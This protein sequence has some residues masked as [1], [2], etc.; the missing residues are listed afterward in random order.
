[1]SLR[2]R[3]RDAVALADAERVEAGGGAL[4]AGV[5][6]GAIDDAIAAH[7]AGDEP[8]RR[9]HEAPRLCA[10]CYA[11][12]FSTSTPAAVSRSMAAS[13]KP[14]SASTSR[15]CCEKRRRRRL[16]AARRAREFH[17]R[18]DAL[19]RAGLDDR[20]AGGGV[21]VVQR[22]LGVEHGAAGQARLEQF[23]RERHAVDVRQPLGD[24]R[25]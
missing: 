7:E 16:E 19:V 25:G 14:C 20:A 6:R 9:H 12:R 8:V 18:A 3:M 23:Q 15:V 5:E 24:D 10:A 13:S 11:R 21:R 22:F 1:M 4:D 2:I 17:R